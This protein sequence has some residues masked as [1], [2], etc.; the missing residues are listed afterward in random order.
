MK[1]NTTKKIDGDKRTSASMAADELV[2]RYAFG[3]NQSCYLG[4][5]LDFFG[6][7]YGFHQ[8]FEVRVV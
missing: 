8:V 5:T 2:L 4:L 6:Q 1:R 3:V 7:S